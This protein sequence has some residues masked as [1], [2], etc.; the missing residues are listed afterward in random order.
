MVYRSM[1][2]QKPG[3]ATGELVDLSLSRVMLLLCYVLTNL[4]GSL[5]TLVLILVFQV[6][7]CMTFNLPETVSIP[8]FS[9]DIHRAE[10]I[11]VSKSDRP[12][13]GQIPCERAFILKD[14][15]HVAISL[16]ELIDHIM[17]HGAPIAWL[18][19]D[20]GN[21]KNPHKGSGINKSTAAKEM[22]KRCRD[23]VERENKRSP[24]KQHLHTW[25]YGPM[26]SLL[27]CLLS[28]DIDCVIILY[29]TQPR[30]APYLILCLT[31][32]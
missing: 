16:D 9:P 29:V 1:H 6:V 24:D 2:R 26:P 32:V 5:R 28:F 11:C 4:G 30:A 12:F 22:L 15:K 13:W 21:D 10:Q 7:A 3:M 14:K 25:C 17:A 18:Q 19:D 27:V 31:C 23:A 20:K 8:P